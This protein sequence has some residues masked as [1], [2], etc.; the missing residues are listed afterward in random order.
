M[1]APPERH[2]QIR[3]S[4]ATV[5]NPPEAE[6]PLEGPVITRHYRGSQA[7]LTQQCDADASRLL[8]DGY[9]VE[10]QEVIPGRRGCLGVS[11]GV[12]TL[13]IWFLFTRPKDV[14]VVTCLR[15]TV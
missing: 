10:S 14:V 11:F 2:E 13:G 12:V 3:A 9:R 5:A 1:E 7:S 6:V 4:V 8:A 15:E